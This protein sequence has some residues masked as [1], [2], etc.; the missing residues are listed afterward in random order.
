MYD[1]FISYS[2]HDSAWVQG[3]VKLLR[4]RKRWNSDENLQ[5]FDYSDS[6]QVGENW[7]V[8][9]ESALQESRFVIPIYSPNYFLSKPSNWEILQK[10]M[11]D[12]D[13]SG[14]TI[15]PCLL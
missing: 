14:R 8:K 4:R 13:A 2:K 3:L 7:L 6:I 10:L 12:M 1:A 5:I 15:L 11:P 9:L